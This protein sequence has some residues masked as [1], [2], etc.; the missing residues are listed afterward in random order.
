MNADFLGTLPCMTSQLFRLKTEVRFLF[1][2]ELQTFTMPDIVD[3][4]RK[5]VNDVLRLHDVLVKASRQTS[6]LDQR[7]LA[8]ASK[9]PTRGIPALSVASEI[10]WDSRLCTANQRKS[11]FVSRVPSDIARERDTQLRRKE[12]RFAAENSDDVQEFDLFPVRQY[13]STTFNQ[14][15]EARMWFLFIMKTRTSAGSS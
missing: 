15:A 11:V 1:S 4:A 3:D 6:F 14:F 9:T 5:R 10:E 8:M 13:E 2:V 12:A 7:S